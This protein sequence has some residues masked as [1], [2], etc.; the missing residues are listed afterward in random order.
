MSDLTV[1][2]IIAIHSSIAAREGAD[3]RMIS[4]AVLHQVTVQVNL[5]ADPFKK[6]AIILFSF[7]AYPPFREGNRE[8]SVCLVKQIIENEGYW[9]DPER[10]NLTGLVQGVES[11]S[12]ET[13]DLEDWLRTHA[14]NHAL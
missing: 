3:S 12:L 6:A 7:S 13:E 4:E 10:E 8:T 14:Q 2:D 9:I 1:D 5:S 11:C